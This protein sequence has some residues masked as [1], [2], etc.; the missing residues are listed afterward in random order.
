MNPLLVRLEGHQY[1]PLRTND[2][3][4]ASGPAGDHDGHLLG[5]Y[6][7]AAAV[8]QFVRERDDADVT[9]TRW[10]APIHTSVCRT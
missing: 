9:T 4:F 8:C 1:T 3:L 7:I 2:D 6:L 5:Q 10:L